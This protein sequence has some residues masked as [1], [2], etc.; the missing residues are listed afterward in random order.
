MAGIFSGKLCLCSIYK[1][2]GVDTVGFPY[3]SLYLCKTQNV[4]DAG[5]ISGINFFFFFKTSSKTIDMHIFVYDTKTF[6]T[7]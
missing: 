5:E 2:P 6:V 7:H 4:F 1:G 3:R